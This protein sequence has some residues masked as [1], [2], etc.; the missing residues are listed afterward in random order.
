M[1]TTTIMKQMW[2]RASAATIDAIVR[3]CDQVFA[4]YELDTS[5]RVAHFM[6]Q[7]THEC[8][9]GTIV[10]ENMNYRAERIIE[11]FGYDK[12]RQ[13]WVHSAQ[14]TDAEA[15]QLAHN[16]QALAERVYGLGNP[17]KAKELG[18]TRTGDG[19]RF[20]GNGML[21]LTG[22]AS[23]AR[24]GRLI[25][26][27]LESNPEMLENPTTSFR[28]AAAEFKAL[29]ALP[30]A[31]RDDVTGVTKKV[32][33]GR[34][35][36]AERTVHLRRWKA[37]LPG[38]EEPVQ[39]P[40]GAPEPAAKKLTQSKIAQGTA[41]TGGLTVVGT[42]AQV[43]EYAQTT[44]DTVSVAKNATDNAVTVVQT[45]KPFL[46][47]MPGVWSGIAIG[48]AVAALVGC[49]YVGWQRYLKLRD[50]GV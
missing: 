17:K 29:G 16:P 33:G 14:V 27:D 26:V 36:L 40:R 24:I 25:G 47:L 20:R 9:A 28:V 2:P 38:I 3:T 22:R 30:F 44:A 46:G 15:A 6:A 10:R 21:Q 34:N 7:I 41:I 12:A 13:R 45:V 32:N 1:L 37:V 43:A 35:G 39:R 23:H 5:L 42:V 8:G 18:N 48:C 19:F 49:L 31:D 50:Q 11:I 4:D